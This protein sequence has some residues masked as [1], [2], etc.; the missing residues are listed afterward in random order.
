V[1]TL[2]RRVPTRGVHD[3]LDDV[4]TAFNDTL[5]RLEHSVGEMRQFSACACSR[6]ANAA[7]RAAR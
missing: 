5:A 7:R 2:E 4:A 1:R 6:A 3:E